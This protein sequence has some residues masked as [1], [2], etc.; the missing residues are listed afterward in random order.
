MRA[1]ISGPGS[2]QE[3][4]PR[5]ITNTPNDTPIKSSG[6]PETPEITTT[7]ASPLIS[8]P[9]SERL[10]VESGKISERSSAGEKRK[11]RGSP[12]RISSDKEHGGG[13]G[14]GRVSRASWEHETTRQE[15]CIHLQKEIVE[16]LDALTV[17]YPPENETLEDRRE[18]LFVSILK[19]T[20][21]KN[22]KKRKSFEEI[23]VSLRELLE[24]KKAVTKSQQPM[25]IER[26]GYRDSDT[27]EVGLVNF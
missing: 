18:R 4:K 6:P 13:S 5:G 23:I 8:R 1:N 11:S 17:G 25:G 19:S 14:S 27:D 15:D 21:H 16:Q 20:L 3:T 9:S 7:I 12:R 24:P 10:A 2:P 22:P 26:P